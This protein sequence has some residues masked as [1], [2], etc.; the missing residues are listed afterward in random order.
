M[1]GP[2]SISFCE[3]ENTSP[4]L[5]EPDLYNV[6]PDKSEK[7]VYIA[8][9]NVLISREYGGWSHLVDV[10]GLIKFRN[11]GLVPVV[12]CNELLCV[13]G[14]NSILADYKL[15][16]SF[17]DSKVDSGPD[18][19]INVHEII[20]SNLRSYRSL[21]CNAE[22]Q[23]LSIKESENT[24]KRYVFGIFERIKIKCSSVIHGSQLQDYKHSR[25]RERKIFE[26]HLIEDKGNW[27]VEFINEVTP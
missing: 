2:Y 18:S 17:L 1:I 8:I 12:L 5:V 14:N 9:Y 21:A 15:S 4:T 13:E 22:N 27:L 23:P 3:N 19:R 26:V 10:T 24:H 20:M 6:F 25:F 11:D 16:I 7:D